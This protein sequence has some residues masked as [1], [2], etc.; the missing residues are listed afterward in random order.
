MLS[1]AH[2]HL[3][4]NEE[5]ALIQQSQQILTIINCDSPEEWEENQHLI[6]TEDQILSFGIHP[7]KASDYSFEE[8]I[9]YLRQARIIGEI[10]LDNVW[11]TV[12]MSRQRQLFDQ[13]LAFAAANKKP[14]VL[15]TKGCEKEILSSIRA[16]PNKYLIHWYSSIDYQQEYIDEGCYFTI[17]IDLEDHPAV[18]K[19]VKAVPSNRL[20]LETDGIG[21]ME[22]ALKRTVSVENYADLLRTHLQHI[23]KWRN[24]SEELIEKTTY[25]NLM[26]FIGQKK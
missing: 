7:W 6:R 11:T 21:A 22:W 19:L 10:G 26:A 24:S 25:Q 3:E 8:V 15:H 2:C 13:Q 23:A 1:D 14:A 16:Y 4:G 17:G 9:P 18:Q 20:L 5:L 12:P